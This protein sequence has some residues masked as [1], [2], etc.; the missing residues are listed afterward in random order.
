MQYQLVLQFPADSTTDFNAF[1]ELEN[2]LEIALRDSHLVDGHDI[3]SGKMNIFIHT[4]DP[5]MAFD[6]ARAEIT[7]ELLG[8][9]KAAFRKLDG[10]EYKWIYPMD[11]PGNFRVA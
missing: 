2:L 1:I 5:I 11:S 6:V 8:G 7:A 10:E 4:N 3:G 9:L